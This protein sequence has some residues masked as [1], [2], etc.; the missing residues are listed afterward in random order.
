MTTGKTLFG[1]IKTIMAQSNYGFLESAEATDQYNSD[2]YCPGEYLK[3]KYA[4]QRVQFEVCINKKGQPQAVDLRLVDDDVWRAPP[5]RSRP[6]AKNPRIDLK[7]I[8][9]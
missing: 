4:G 1:T 6:L 3:G 5:A 7:G 2:V 9:S 8:M